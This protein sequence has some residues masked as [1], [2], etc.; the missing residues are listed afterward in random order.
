M[1]LAAEAA[2]PLALLSSVVRK[3]GHSAAEAPNSR[4]FLNALDALSTFEYLQWLAGFQKRKVSRSC[5]AQRMHAPGMHAPGY[6]KLGL[7]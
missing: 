7:A 6:G 4:C 1:A 5:T 3:G 2:I